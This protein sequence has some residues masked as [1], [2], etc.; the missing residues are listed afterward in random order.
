MKKEQ[1]EIFADERRAVAFNEVAKELPLNRLEKLMIAVM[2]IIALLPVVHL[3]VVYISLP[4][5]VVI[6]TSAI[7]GYSARWIL[8]ILAVCNI[9]VVPA[10]VGKN[11]YAQATTL[12]KNDLKRSAESVIHAYR[13]WLNLM[14][15]LCVALIGYVLEVSIRQAQGSV[16]S[17]SVWML[18]GLV[19]L[20]VVSTVVYHYWLRKVPGDESSKNNF[21]RR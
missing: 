18:A 8:P 4:T 17:T 15:I 2:A 1:A 5:D 10:A 19:V 3:V 12:S 11:F 9:I 13:F 16:I 14:G 7:S 6:E 20:A 21:G